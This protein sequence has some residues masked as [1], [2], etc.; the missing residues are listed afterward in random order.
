MHLQVEKLGKIENPKTQPKC[1]LR[2]LAFLV[3]NSTNLRVGG[4]KT[5]LNRRRYTNFAK[6]FVL[7]YQTSEI[8]S[9]VSIWYLNAFISSSSTSLSI[10][11][12]H[13]ILIWPWKIKKERERKLGRRRG[14]LHK[15]SYKFNVLCKEI[16]IFYS[17]M[18]LC[19]LNFILLK[20]EMNE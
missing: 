17:L 3:S 12:V 16:K 9:T 18:K 10:C 8:L 14:R 19:F 2:F 7:K 20:E 1:Y 6:A 4:M 13:K 11:F 5:D 15:E